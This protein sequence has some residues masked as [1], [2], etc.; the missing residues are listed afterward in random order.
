MDGK[1]HMERR[2]VKA[3]LLRKNTNIKFS[4]GHRMYV[5]AEDYGD[6]DSVSDN[7]LK[8]IFF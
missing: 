5:G 6:D 2:L 4:T 8:E 3:T 7:F 1:T